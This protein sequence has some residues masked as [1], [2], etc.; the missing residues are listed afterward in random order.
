MW[1]ALSSSNVSVCS[2][3][4]WSL[5][6][7]SV[8]IA[9]VFTVCGPMSASTYMVS[10]YARFFVDVLAHRRRCGFAP[11]ASKASHR[12]PACIALKAA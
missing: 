3:V 8:G 2:V 12:S 1:Y 4:P 7:L 6:A 11:R 9:I 5:K 10:A